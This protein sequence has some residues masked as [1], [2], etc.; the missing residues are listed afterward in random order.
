MDNVVYFEYFIQANLNWKITRIAFNERNKTIMHCLF[1]AFIWKKNNHLRLGKNSSDCFSRAW[2]LPWLCVGT[3]LWTQSPAK[4]AG[5]CIEIHGN[6]R[7]LSM[8][9]VSFQPLKAFATLRKSTE[10]I[11]W[12]T[13]S[14]FYH[15]MS[16]CACC[17]WKPKKKA[18]K[19][20]VGKTSSKFLT[21]F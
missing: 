6:R 17:W 21:V 19:S 3:S 15:V 1:F 16:D 5:C 11:S 2:L 12:W 9:E 14:P 20:Y 10:M 18:P 13:P 4:R 8:K 7:I